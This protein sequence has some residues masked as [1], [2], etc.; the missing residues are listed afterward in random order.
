MSFLPR[1]CSLVIFL[2]TVACAASN[3]IALVTNPLVPT[4]R[5]WRCQ[6]HADR[7]RH[8]LRLRCRSA[9]RNGNEVR[10]QCKAI[11]KLTAAV[12]AAQI[13]APGTASVAADPMLFIFLYRRPDRP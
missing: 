4:S 8:W 2:S 3:P 5:A 6:I 12:P 9:F 11:P 7:E 1:L 13:A 10:G